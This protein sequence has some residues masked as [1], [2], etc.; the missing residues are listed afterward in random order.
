MNKVKL[1]KEFINES[2]NESEIIYLLN[3]DNE[4]SRE[5]ALEN[6]GGIPINFNNKLYIGYTLKDLPV[7]FDELGFTPKS[8]YVNQLTKKGDIYTLP[9]NVTFLKKKKR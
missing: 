8:I 6:E 5:T 9:N 3:Y 4:N 1:F 7:T 2:Y